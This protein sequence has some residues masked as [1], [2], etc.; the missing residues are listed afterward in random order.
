MGL[1]HVQDD[2]VRKFPRLNGT[3]QI[4]HAQN[5]GASQCCHFQ[6]R[7]GIHNGRIKRYYFMKFC[8]C[9]H[10]PEHVQSIV[11]GG[12]VRSQSDPDGLFQHLRYRSDPGG[13]FHGT[14]RVMGNAYAQI[15]K[16]RNVF[17]IK[18][19]AMNRDR[20]IIQHTQI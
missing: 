10:F 14:D 13:Q 17:R 9:I 19:V 11:T 7:W 15:G 18:P 6:N 3:D 4:F 8:C 16:D 2:D 12:T 20:L 5:P 1:I